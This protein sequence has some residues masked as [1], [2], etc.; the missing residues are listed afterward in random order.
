MS[1]ACTI[2]ADTHCNDLPTPTHPCGNCGLPFSRDH[3]ENW[4]YGY[5]RNKCQVDGFGIECKG[6][7][8]A[9]LDAA[10]VLSPLSA[11]VAPTVSSAPMANA[12]WPGEPLRVP[13]PVSKD[14]WDYVPP[15]P[16]VRPM[17]L[18]NDCGVKPRVSDDDDCEYCQ[19]CYNIDDGYYAYIPESSP[20]VC[21]RICSDCKVNPCMDDD[22][23]CDFCEKCYL[24]EDGYYV[25]IDWKNTCYN[26]GN[27]ALPHVD[28]C[29]ICNFAYDPYPPSK[30]VD[31]EAAHSDADDQHYCGACGISF[32]RILCANWDPNP[33]KDCCNGI[34]E[35]EGLCP[36]CRHVA[37]YS[38][39]LTNQLLELMVI[40]SAVAPYLGV[41][42]ME[43]AL[44]VLNM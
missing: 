18:C 5:F 43:A 1:D 19:D 14:S 44:L 42:S 30:A 3:C 4:D 31:S 28:H 40:G 8:P 2:C 7:C 23:Y 33:S 11:D 24:N 29:G 38:G 10:D 21:E 36:Y 13:K 32:S 17:P 20:R 22:E 37:A 25:E 12:Q 6:F 9:C 15:P 34:E 27:L 35:C 16:K 39:V 26:C 41:S